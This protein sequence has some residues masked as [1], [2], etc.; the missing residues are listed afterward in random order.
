M[1]TL[2]AILNGGSQSPKVS[3]RQL[4]LALVYALGALIVLLQLRSLL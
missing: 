3:I 1:K 2:L 4:G